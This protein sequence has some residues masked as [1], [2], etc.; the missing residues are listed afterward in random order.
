L[1]ARFIDAPLGLEMPHGL[2]DWRND[3]G[4]QNCVET[5]S[6]AGATACELAFIEGVS[7][8]NAVTGRTSATPRAAG[9]MTPIHVRMGG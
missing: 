8:S 3:K 2:N 1:P 6:K 5:R 4:G 9:E 7:R